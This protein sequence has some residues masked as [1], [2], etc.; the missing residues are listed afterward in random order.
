MNSVGTYPGK[1]EF[2]QLAQQ[3]NI[4][5]VYTDVLTDMET[6]VSLYYKLVGDE[7][8]FI[9]ESADSSKNFG[10]YSFIGADPF[11]IVT[12]RAQYS[13]IKLD[14][15]IQEIVGSPIEV[16]Q[17][18]MKNFS[19][20]EFSDLPPF[21]GGGVGYFSYESI[22]TWERVRGQVLPDEMI[23]SELLFCQV[24]IVMDHL[25]HSTK[26]MYLARLTAEENASDTYE[27]ALKQLEKWLKKLQA[28]VTLPRNKMSMS[29]GGG[30]N[31]VDKVA[32]EKFIK[33]VKTAKEHI[34]AGD[35]FQVVL[36]QQFRS[37]LK[38]HPFSLYRRLRQLNPSPYMFY[39]NLGPRKL[40]GASP[41][42]LVKLA[43]G[44][45]LT[46]PIAG[47]RPRGK[48][49]REDSQLAAELLADVKERAEHAML[50]DLGRNDIG[51]IS[52]PGSV[53]VRRMME[54]ENF[55]HVM[56]LVS[57]VA[58]KINPQYEALDVLTACFPAGTVSGAPKVRAM[59]IINDL[60]DA[61][62]GPYAGA[63]GYLDFRGS[64]D[65]CITIRTIVID[66]DEVKVQA[67]AG[68]VADSVPEK[69]YQEI[70]QKA[71]V[72]FQVVGEDE[73]DGID[74]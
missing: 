15:Q 16:L 47:T 37:K 17:G 61:A 31:S 51:R 27:V 57:E 30:T 8:G 19:F 2:C 50:V 14:G 60:E 10:R 62:R 73:D 22:G 25:T 28:T 56:H 53:T 3:Y 55:S 48:D 40:V 33:S 35:I 72:L 21:T 64:M 18:F 65:T 52:L 1:I 32:Q 74:H 7:V 45:V 5:P 68:I 38:K 71:K 20:P 42:M 43:G 4:I 11:A 46:Y 39:I 70:L 41:E 58:G 54:I 36:S 6:P 13:E 69:E 63:V 34:L 9:L 29:L 49:V 24:I 44:E 59:E 23:L 67:G 26:L 66:G 12:G